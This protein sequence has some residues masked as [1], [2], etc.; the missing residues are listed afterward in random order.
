MSV[1]R[2]SSFILSR[3]LY[4]RRLFNLKYS[5]PLKQHGSRLS[6]VIR[7]HPFKLHCSCL[8][9]YLRTLLFH[10]MLN[11]S[12]L[13]ARFLATRVCGSFSATNKFNFGCGVTGPHMLCLWV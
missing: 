10:L 12:L 8:F 5:R 4:V 2:A 1:S 3:Q 11:R 13:F 9:G 6:K 7:S